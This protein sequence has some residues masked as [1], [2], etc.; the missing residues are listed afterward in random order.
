MLCCIPLNCIIKAW[1]LWDLNNF[2]SSWFFLLSI[3]WQHRFFPLLFAVVQLYSIGRIPNYESAGQW[4][5]FQC[6]MIIRF[7]RFSVKWVYQILTSYKSSEW[8]RPE[9]STCYAC[10]LLT[11]NFNASYFFIKCNWSSRVSFFGFSLENNSKNIRF[12]KNIKSLQDE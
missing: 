11:S 2:F 7:I 3:K 6:V 1:V 12:R 8:I 4:V 9:W 10:A 5:H